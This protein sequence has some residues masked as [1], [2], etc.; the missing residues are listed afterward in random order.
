L[1][2]AYKLNEEERKLKKFCNIPNARDPKS[3]HLGINI[4]E[5]KVHGLFLLFFF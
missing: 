5:E 3:C 1:E 4:E 2:K